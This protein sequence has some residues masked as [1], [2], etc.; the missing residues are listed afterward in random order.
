VFVGDTVTQRQSDTV[1]KGDV[2]NPS[3]S[4]RR[5]VLAAAKKPRPANRP[6]LTTY[7]RVL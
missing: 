7:N 2:V 6:G 5:G 1:T 4:P 3:V